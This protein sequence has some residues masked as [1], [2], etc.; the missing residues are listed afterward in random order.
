MTWEDRRIEIS[1][2][3]AHTAVNPAG[4]EFHFGC[5]AD[6]E[7]CAVHG[8]P[9]DEHTWFP[10]CFWQFAHC[11]GCA[12]HLGWYFTGAA[13]FFGLVLERLAPGSEPPQA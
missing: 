5:F 9:T 12:A 4:I 7:G 2:Q 8:E 11:R 10:G 6:A 13:T 1:G 3:H